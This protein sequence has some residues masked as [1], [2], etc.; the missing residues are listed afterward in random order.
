MT[1]LVAEFGGT[2]GLFLGI[3][4]ILVAKNVDNFLSLSF[5]KYN[6]PYLWTVYKNLKYIDVSLYL[7]YLL[8]CLF[9][10][11]FL[12][13]FGLPAIERYTNQEVMVLNTVK[14]TD[15]IRTPAITISALNPQTMNGWKGNI[16][17][18]YD[19][20][21]SMCK[22]IDNI[23]SCIS[24]KTFKQEEVFM[25]VKLGFTTMQSLLNE[26]SCTQD[27]ALE[28]NG[29]SFT[30][31][32]NKTI[33]TNFFLDQLFISFEHKQIVKVMIHDQNYYVGDNFI[34][35][36]SLLFIIDPNTTANYFHYL[37]LTEVEELDLPADP[38]NNDPA[39]NFQACV[40]ESLSSQVGCRLKWDRLSDQERP[41]CSKM[42]QYR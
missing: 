24:L 1:A 9:C 18:Y 25:D 16:S 12:T 28:T 4:F 15:G 29:M 17:G 10:I 34:G 31:Q 30:L 22:D 20:L 23:T 2:L 5:N 32:I 27:F 21:P 39:Y 8:K 36:P 6:F 41:V 7:R 19:L 42:D 26:V 37:I 3:S 33:G 11:L 35:P 14:K 13:Y 38:C 40:R